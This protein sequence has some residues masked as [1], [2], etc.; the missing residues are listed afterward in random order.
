M[1][2]PPPGAAMIRLTGRLICAAAEEAATVR[3]HLPAH[4]RLSR[5]DAG[6]LSF[7]IAQSADPLVFD[8]DES[9]QTRADFEAHRDRA[10]QSDWARATAD[11]RRDYRL[12]E[13]QD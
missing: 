10:R 5:A 8:V 4:L 3:L 2:L 1:P 11:L 12:D 13:G 7:K 9:F 6:C